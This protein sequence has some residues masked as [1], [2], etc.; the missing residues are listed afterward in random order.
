MCK[1][2]GDGGNWSDILDEIRT[3]PSRFDSVR[4]KYFINLQK[5]TCRNVICYYSGWQEGKITSTSIEDSDMEG[6]M[7]AV[8][9]VDKS[10]GLTLI[11]H[12]PGGDPTAAEAIV[13][14]LRDLFKDD[15]EVVV[16]HMAMSAGTMMACA[17]R[18]IWM[19]KHSSLG[20]VDPQI[21][22]LPAYNILEEFKNAKVDLKENPDNFN[23]WRLLLSKYPAAFV[24]YAQDAVELSGSLIEDWLKNVMFKDEDDPSEMVSRIVENLN[25]HE[26]SKAHA[27]HFNYEHIKELGLNVKL[28]E[29][30]QDFQNAVLSLHHAYMIALQQTRAS[31]IIEGAKKAYI[32]SDPK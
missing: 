12:T 27:R 30:D 10:K 23:Y 29:D 11:L 7:S 13:T 4:H 6:F 32:V 17:S 21:S 24:K 1:Q 8:D 20:P 31:K 19:G 15:I 16:P 5:A 22:G 3:V 14:Y 25:E 9:G 26:H 2:D 18:R 28:L